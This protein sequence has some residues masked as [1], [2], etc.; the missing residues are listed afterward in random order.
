MEP[1]FFKAENALEGAP[2]TE[3]QFS[4]FNGAAF[5]QSGKYENRN[6]CFRT[7]RGFNGAAFFQS[8]KYALAAVP[9]AAAQASMEP[10]FFKAENIFAT[11]EKA[12]RA[13]RFNGAAFFQSGK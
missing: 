5:F 2:T 4:G 6:Q 7:N 9:M 11:Q 3:N 10:L 12:L 1:L 13:G 8:G